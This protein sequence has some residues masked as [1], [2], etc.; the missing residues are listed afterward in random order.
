MLIQINPDKLLPVK[1][2][3]SS[4]LLPWITYE[5]SLTERLHQKAGDARLEVLGQQWE[6][7]NWWDK[8]VL[9]IKTE[10]VFHREILMWSGKEACWYARTILPKETYRAEPSFFDRLQNESMG[11]LIFN[12]SRIKRA[13]LMHYPICKQSIEYS[14]LSQAMHGNATV[15]WVR[16]SAFVLQG[17]FPFYLLETLLPALERYSN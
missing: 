6:A 12:E 8:Q 17:K 9:H 7:P 15:L 11:E 3:L 4:I 16:A 14:W 2:E 5:D 13:Y 10:P 1:C